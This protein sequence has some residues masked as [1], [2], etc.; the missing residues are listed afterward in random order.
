VPS[1]AHLHSLIDPAAGARCAGTR[2]GVAV[3]IALLLVTG[4]Q[5]SLSAVSH[6]P[7]VTSGADGRRRSSDVEHP[8][9]YPP[10]RQRAH[11]EAQQLPPNSEH[12]PGEDPDDRSHHEADQRFTELHR[13]SPPASSACATASVLSPATSVRPAR[14][15]TIRAG[16]RG[17]PRSSAAA[18][19]TRAPA[20]PRAGSNR[21]RPWAAAD[22]GSPPPATRST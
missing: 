11:D 20:R 15:G 14:G 3:A 2:V 7:S 19:A 18:S 5:E 9:R 16:V 8:L 12:V 22:G 21:A 4:I 6:R 10:R 13:R 1:P 17:A